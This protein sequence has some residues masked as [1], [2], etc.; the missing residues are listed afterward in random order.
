MLLSVLISLAA[1]VTMS[2]QPLAA[3]DTTHRDTTAGKKQHSVVA[4]TQHTVQ[5]AATDTKTAGAKAGTSTKTEGAKAGNDAKSTTGTAVTNAKSGLAQAG[6]DTKTVTK[7][8]ADASSKQ[9]SKLSTA[10][11]NAKAGL[12]QAGIG[13]GKTVTTKS[14]G[15]TKP[16]KGTAA[17]SGHTGKQ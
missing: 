10:F 7:G 12:S 9:K 16:A 17:D 3:Q 14:G 1:V 5:K 6:V 13:G 4:N 11:D 15:S 2:G 8:G